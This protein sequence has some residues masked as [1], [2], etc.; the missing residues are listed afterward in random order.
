MDPQNSKTVLI[1]DITNTHTYWQQELSLNTIEF[2]IKEQFEMP[3]PT[4]MKSLHEIRE[5]KPSIDSAS[6]NSI[7]KPIN[8]IPKTNLKKT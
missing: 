4:M 1:A 3:A 6:L 7:Q 2:R 8:Q 5:T